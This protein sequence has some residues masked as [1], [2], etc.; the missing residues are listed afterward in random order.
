MHPPQEKYSVAIVYMHQIMKHTE[1][2]IRSSG[3]GLRCG[4]ECVAAVHG[5]LSSKVCMCLM[6]ETK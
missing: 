3:S 1:D 2:K 5:G 6:G 4:C